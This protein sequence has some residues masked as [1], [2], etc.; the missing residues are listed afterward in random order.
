MSAEKASRPSAVHGTWTE[1]KRDGWVYFRDP[2]PHIERS[3]SIPDSP[4]VLR[5]MA[6]LAMERGYLN[7]AQTYELAA[8]DCPRWCG[9]KGCTSTRAEATEQRAAKAKRVALARRVEA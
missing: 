2:D 6:R 5:A 4:V 1:S 3:Q 8:K 7:L 9:C